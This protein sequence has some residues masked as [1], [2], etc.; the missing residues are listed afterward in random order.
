MTKEKYFERM[1]VA[2]PKARS[3]S[4]TF[5]PEKLRKFVYQIWD[6]AVESEHE[7]D[8][9]EAPPMPGFLDDLLTGKGFQ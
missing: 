4:T 9:Q 6:R 5:T 7:L 1:L 3:G 8:K 2:S